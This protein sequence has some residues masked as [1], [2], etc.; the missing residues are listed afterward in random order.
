MVVIHSS[1]GGGNLTPIYNKVAT[2]TYGQDSPAQNMIEYNGQIVVG[3]NNGY[4]IAITSDNG[5]ILSVNP[6]NN[7][8]IQDLTISDDKQ[9]FIASATDRYELFYV[10]G[11]QNVDSYSETSCVTADIRKR[12]D[13]TEQYDVI[14][15]GT[16]AGANNVAFGIIYDTLEHFGVP[17]NFSYEGGNIRRI[18]F[19][20]NEISTYAPEPTGTP[21]YNLV[22]SVQTSNV[23]T[24]F[25]NGQ[26]YTFSGHTGFPQALCVSKNDEVYSGAGDGKVYKL[27]PDMQEQWSYTYGSVVRSIFV[28]DSDNVYVTG[29]NG[30]V[31]KLDS[32]GNEL[33]NFDVY[34]GVAR[35]V[36]V[37]KDGYIYVGGDNNNIIKFQVTYS[38]S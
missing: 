8:M 10:D 25:Y 34:G 28:D 29:A 19:F 17:T 7:S 9:Y 24:S 13:S 5:D 31:V 2:F 26:W 38:E 6:I 14:M 37:D 20:N 33:W 23:V 21:E 11:F 4:I 3:T 1:L 15:G 12:A 36:V 30:N 32:D 35:S 16:Q 18:R 27:S 22:F